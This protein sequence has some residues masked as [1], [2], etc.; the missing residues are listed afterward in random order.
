MLRLASIIG[1]LILLFLIQKVF[2][3][4]TT[5]SQPFHIIGVDAGTG[6]CRVGI[7]NLNGDNPGKPVSQVDV[8]YDTL[9]PHPGYAEQ[10][11]DD[12][13]CHLQIYCFL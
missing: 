10:R 9:F 13:K 12:C 1:N 8:A 4:S 2:S 6:S 7:F 5:A 3:D 11:P